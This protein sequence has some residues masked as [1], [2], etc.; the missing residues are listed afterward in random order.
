MDKLDKIKEEI[1][2]SVLIYDLKSMHNSVI[3]LINEIE[4]LTYNMNSILIN[5]IFVAYE[6]HDYLYMSDLLEYQL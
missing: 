2:S 3:K 4:N 5:E 6:R 1:I